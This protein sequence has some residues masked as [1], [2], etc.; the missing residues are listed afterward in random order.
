MCRKA[1]DEA[2]RKGLQEEAV[3]HFARAKELWPPDAN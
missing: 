2:L 3:E 1:G